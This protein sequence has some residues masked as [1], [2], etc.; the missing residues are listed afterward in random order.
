MRGGHCQPQQLDALP[1]ATADG[2]DLAGKF[3]IVKFDCAIGSP[4][5]FPQQ[6]VHGHQYMNVVRMC[7]TSATSKATDSGTCTYS[8]SCS[9]ARSRMS[10]RILRNTD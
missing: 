5:H 8:H 1:D 9:Q 4:A 2:E 7:T 6:D 10:R 3:R